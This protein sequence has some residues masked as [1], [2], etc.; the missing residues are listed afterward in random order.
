MTSQQT[1][2]QIFILSLSDGSV[3]TG[4]IFP[5]C[6]GMSEGYNYLASNSYRNLKHHTF[7]EFIPNLSAF[8]LH[9]KAKLT[10]FVS[11]VNP[12]FGFLLNE[13]TKQLLDRFK[14][15]PHKFYDADIQQNNKIHNAYFLF[16]F[17][18]DFSD[19]IDFNKTI[20]YLWDTFEESESFQVSNVD[21]LKKKYKSVSS[22]VS[23]KSHKIVFQKRHT[24][25][26]DIF[27]LSF[28]DTS[29]YISQ[30]LKTALEE[31]NITGIEI[32]PTDVI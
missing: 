9:K 19:K 15:P 1:N 24:F 12:Y 18:S 30:R 3:D 29:T 5:Q 13:R 11:T 6:Q 17:I 4:N 16:H 2:S 23:I 32:V 25:D 22:L 7:P 14:L 31:A 28:F 10:D 21:E 26:F 8:Q 20:F 27:R